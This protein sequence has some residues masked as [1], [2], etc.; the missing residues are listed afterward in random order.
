MRIMK[1]KAPLSLDLAT[2]H[3]DFNSF[4]YSELYLLVLCLWGIIII[5]FSSF[6]LVSEC[7]RLAVIKRL[8]NPACILNDVGRIA[9]GSC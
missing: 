1:I 4:S 6:D 8:K 7:K 5:F 9:A 2:R 3:C